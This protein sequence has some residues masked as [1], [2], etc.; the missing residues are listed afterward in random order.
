MTAKQIKWYNRYNIV[1]DDDDDDDNGN[2]NNNNNN[3]N[4]NKGSREDLKI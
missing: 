4:N 3:N 1:N 2:G